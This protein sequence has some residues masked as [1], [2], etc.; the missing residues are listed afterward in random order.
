[1]RSAYAIVGIGVLIVGVTAYFAFNHTFTAPHDTL[2][3]T[4]T[5]SMNDTESLALTSSAFKND[6]LIPEKYTCDGDATLN[7]EL[8]ISGTPEEAK[9]LVLIVEDPDVPK[10][11]KPDGMFDHW[12]LFNIPP[13]TLK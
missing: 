1:M 6:G 7:P 13:G 10:A 4:T 8:L 3:S 2:T 9:S 11:L 12:V 5:S